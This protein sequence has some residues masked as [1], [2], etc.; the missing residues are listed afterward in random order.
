M[1]SF[2]VSG[3]IS[4]LYYSDRLL[5]FPLGLFGIAIATVILPSL[6]QRYVDRNPREFHR[7][8]DWAV[9]MIWLLGVPAMVGM[10]MLATPMLRV[11]FM[12]GEFD[13]SDVTHASYSLIAYMCGLLFFMLIKVLAPGYYARQDTKTPVRYGIVAMVANMLFNLALVLPFGYV[14]LAGATAMSAVINA[15]LL[16]SGL[17]RRGVYKLSPFTLFFMLRVVVSATI[18]AAVLYY[19]F[20][21]WPQWLTTS[22]HQSAIWLVEAI[23]LAIVVYLVSLVALGGRLSHLKSSSGAVSDD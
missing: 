18:M 14:G 6:S 7:T 23:G 21:H 3:S 2:L 17:H 19:V 8:M 11:L 5:E 10:M 4:W 9:R 20:P 16:Y 1:A 12:R 13:G 22:W 15:G